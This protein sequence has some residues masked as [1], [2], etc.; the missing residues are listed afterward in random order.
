MLLRRLADHIRNVTFEALPSEAVAMAR[1]GILD[2]IGVTLAG[3]REETTAVVRRALRQT[4]APG[5]AL[6]FGGSER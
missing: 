6:I 3:A 5:P 4:A 2:T 1:D